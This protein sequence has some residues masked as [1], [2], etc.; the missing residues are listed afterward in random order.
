MNC[1]SDNIWAFAMIVVGSAL[2]ITAAI[3]GNK[4]LMALGGT[5]A[6]YGAGTFRSKTADK[7]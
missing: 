7:Q 6:G 5:V 2:G 4:D 1:V 3:L